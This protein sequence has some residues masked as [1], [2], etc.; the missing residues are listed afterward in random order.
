MNEGWQIVPREPTGNMQHSFRSSYRLKEND[1]ASES[2]TEH[3]Q[4]GGGPFGYGYRA[5][6]ATAPKFDDEELVNCIFSHIVGYIDTSWVA[7]EEEIKQS[8]RDGM[9]FPLTPLE[10][11]YI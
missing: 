1:I 2:P 5:M 3:P 6:L 10:H 4:D 8:I 7:T 9:K 11:S